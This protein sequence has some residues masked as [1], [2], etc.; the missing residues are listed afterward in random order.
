MTAI[1]HYLTEFCGFGSQLCQIDCNLTRTVCDK[2]VP[3]NLVF[4]NIGLMTEDAFFFKLTPI[5][6]LSDLII[7]QPSQQQ[8]SFCFK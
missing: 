6:S 3:Q 5:V 1:L 2:N 7:A 8:L 4:G